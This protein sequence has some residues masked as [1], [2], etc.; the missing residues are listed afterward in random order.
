MIINGVT[1]KLKQVCIA[2]FCETQ[3]QGNHK[4]RVF[5]I[6]IVLNTFTN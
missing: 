3:S 5:K 4:S 2:V 1:S 6:N